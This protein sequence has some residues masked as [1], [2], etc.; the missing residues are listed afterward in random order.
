VR[1]GDEGDKDSRRRRPSDHRWAGE[2][3]DERG[4][5]CVV[6]PAPW[7]GLRKAAGPTRNGWLLA[8]AMRLAQDH[9]RLS[10]LAFPGGDGTAD[11]VRRARAAGVEVEEIA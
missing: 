2:W 10:V 7:K 9:A 6:L 4:K 1:R 8:V 5:P 3:A 11:M